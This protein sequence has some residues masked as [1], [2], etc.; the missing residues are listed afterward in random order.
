M[1]RP[2]LLITILLCGAPLTAFPAGGDGG[3]AG[4]DTPAPAAT[5]P[6]N[7]FG[8]PQRA[9]NLLDE[10]AGKLRGRHVHNPKGETL[11]TVE[12]IVRDRRDK[13]VSAVISVGGFLGIGEHRV[14]VP[15][16]QLRLRGKQLVLGTTMTKDELK[17]EPAYHPSSFEPVDG[18]ET[19]R[20]AI[21]ER[22]P[23]ISAQMQGSAL[24]DRLD[25]DGDGRL[26]RDEASADPG[27]AS[28]WE[29]ADSNGD[30]WI[31]RDEFAAFEANSG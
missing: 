3:A 17:N 7:R 19:L 22:I 23:P 25:Q 16:N 11:G 9:N 13:S 15:V 4:A 5:P 1:K 26:G 31:D 30:G 28:G 6:Q 8:G 18:G 24:F 2:L 12:D 27:L 10:P 20:A 29:R 14:T 21:D